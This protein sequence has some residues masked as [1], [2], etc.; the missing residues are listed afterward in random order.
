MSRGE[1]EGTCGHGEGDGALPTSREEGIDDSK[2]I[3]EPHCTGV[4][5]VYTRRTDDERGPYN[6]SCHSHG[7]ANNT[8][9]RAHNV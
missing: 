9:I 4:T 5:P 2:R 6:G 1:F 3:S 7:P 8:Y